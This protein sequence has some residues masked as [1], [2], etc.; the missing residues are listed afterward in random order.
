MDRKRGFCYLHKGGPE[1]LE[2]S[3]DN[4]LS[5]LFLAQTILFIFTILPL[6][7]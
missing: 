7:Y 2:R 3:L 4:G 6:L 1:L 5:A